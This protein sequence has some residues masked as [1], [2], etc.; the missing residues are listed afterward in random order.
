MS[1][2]NAN[3]SYYQGYGSR[4]GRNGCVQCQICHKFGHDAYS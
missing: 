1:H 4:S 3:N 2:V